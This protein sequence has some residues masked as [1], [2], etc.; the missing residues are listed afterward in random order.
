MGVGNLAVMKINAPD[1]LIRQFEKLNSDFESIAKEAVRAGAGVLADRVRANLA[2]N[3]SDSE[4]STGDLLDS[5]GI[6][7]ARVNTDGSVDAKVGFDS[8]GYDRKGVP[9]ILKARV[10]ESGSSVQAKRPFFGPAVKATREKVRVAMKQK[11]SERLE[12]N[13]REMS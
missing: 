6:A 3:L 2:S 1:K 12:K 5:L 8:P 10:M 4:H 7:P 13:A 11:V 9:N